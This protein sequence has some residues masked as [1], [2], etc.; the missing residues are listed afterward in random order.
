M[1]EIRESVGVPPVLGVRVL[2]NSFITDPVSAAV[3]A[4]V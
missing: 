4:P 1:T 2:E 3:G